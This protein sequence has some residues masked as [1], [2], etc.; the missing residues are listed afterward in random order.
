MTIN[1]AIMRSHDHERGL[2][3]THVP[4]IAGVIKQLLRTWLKCHRDWLSRSITDALTIRNIAAAQVSDFLN[5]LSVF[6]AD[7]RNAA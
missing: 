5:G 7:V 4:V 2:N 6:N 1:A 3:Q